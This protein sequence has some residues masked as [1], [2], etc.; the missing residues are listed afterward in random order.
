MA[1]TAFC[2]TCNSSFTVE[3]RVVGKV[4]ASSLAAVVG[5]KFSDNP[6]VAVLLGVAG[7]AIGH[8]IDTAIGLRCKTPGCTAVLQVVEA[9][10]AQNTRLG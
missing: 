8:Q 7:L 9:V 1:K 3:D 6:L 2:P 4:I 10:V 5:K